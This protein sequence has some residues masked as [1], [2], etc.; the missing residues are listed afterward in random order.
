MSRSVRLRTYQRGKQFS[1]R[2]LTIPKKKSKNKGPLV[3]F[4]M[5]VFELELQ[6][7]CRKKGV[8]VVGFESRKETCLNQKGRESLSHHT[9][10]H[11]ITNKTNKRK[12]KQTRNWMQKGVTY[13]NG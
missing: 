7:S 6:I 1:R 3:V 2:K 13:R 10:T 11:A 5:F 9:F 8:R 12:N 4:I